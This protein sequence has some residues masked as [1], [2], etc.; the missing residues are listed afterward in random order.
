MHVYAIQS[1]TTRVEGKHQYDPQFFEI[2]V[3]WSSAQIEK[4]EVDDEFDNPGI[5]SADKYANDLNKQQHHDTM[6]VSSEVSGSQWENTN[7]R[8]VSDGSQ[9]DNGDRHKGFF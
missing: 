7:N 4:N 2:L 3:Y 5:I 8:R 1:S 6:I 9:N